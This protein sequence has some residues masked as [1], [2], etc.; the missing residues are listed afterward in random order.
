MLESRSTGGDSWQLAQWWQLARW[1][2][3][4]PCS[5]RCPYRPADSSAGRTLWPLPL[6]RGVLSGG[7]APRLLDVDPAGGGLPLVVAGGG[8]GDG[9][10][11]GL[12]ELMAGAAGGPAVAAAGPA[13]FFE[14]HTVLEVGLAGVPGAG[15]EAAL[16]VS[17]VDEV[18]E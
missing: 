5:S 13:A 14:R 12:L 2:P 15:G 4:S 9:P 3:R 10:A 11:V 1:P 8:L 7:V 6:G 16:A 17:Y 18:A